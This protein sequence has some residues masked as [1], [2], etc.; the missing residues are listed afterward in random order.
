MCWA[1]RWDWRD[2]VWTWRSSLLFPICAAEAI[3]P[4]RSSS[5]V[6][7]LAALV[8]WEA[9]ERVAAVPWE[10]ESDLVRPKRMLGG[11]LAAVL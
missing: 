2:L 5:A 7:R 11:N 8:G 10:A 4:S 3:L 9:P 1:V 6:R